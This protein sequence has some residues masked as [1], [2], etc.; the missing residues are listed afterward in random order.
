M[1]K[2]DLPQ[3]HATAPPAIFLV[4]EDG[5]E[6]EPFNSD[7]V[8]WCQDRIYDA[9]IP[10]IRYDQAENM[11]VTQ[12]ASGARA[13]A[14]AILA[15]MASLLTSK[16]W[17]ALWFRIMLAT[18]PTKAFNV[19]KKQVPDTKIELLEESLRPSNSPMP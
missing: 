15:S 17:R 10:Y 7:G 3:S 12:L 19:L 11:M 13:G 9:D 8:A 18:A 14:A 4:I 2:A 5:D 1:P 16:S 6:D